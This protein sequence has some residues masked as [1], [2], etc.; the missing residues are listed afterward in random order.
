MC[1][2]LI[3]WDLFVGQI[4]RDFVS[5]NEWFVCGETY[6]YS[7]YICNWQNES[8]VTGILKI[9]SKGKFNIRTWNLSYLEDRYDLQK[10]RFYYYTECLQGQAKVKISKKRSSGKAK[11]KF[12]PKIV[13]RSSNFI[14]MTRNNEPKIFRNQ[15][16]FIFSF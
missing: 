5:C 15:E 4:G 7:L 10:N 6:I 3:D 13:C 2:L 1:S 14:W 9:Y 16:F 8:S 11:V 12:F